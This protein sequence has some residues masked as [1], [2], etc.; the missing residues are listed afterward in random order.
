MFSLL[1]ARGGL[2][3]GRGECDNHFILDG[4][5]CNTALVH[6]LISMLVLCSPFPHAGLVKGGGHAGPACPPPPVYVSD[7]KATAMT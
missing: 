4:S 6:L 5:L 1:G 7:W 2:K 3:Q